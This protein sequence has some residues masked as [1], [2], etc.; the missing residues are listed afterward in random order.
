MDLLRRAL[1]K[2][3]N[4]TASRQDGQVLTLFAAGLVGLCGFVG[5]SIDV[6]QLVY[7]ASDVQKIADAAALAG[8]Q[9]LPNTSN[10]TSAAT[11]YAAENGTA[12]LDITFTNS[13]HTIEV[14][15][16][17]YVE[18]TFLK[19]IGLG[20]RTISRS[21]TVVAQNQVI[22]GYTL[23]NTAPFIIW[24]GSRQTE[25]NPGDQH[26]ALHTCVG[27][28]YTFLDSNW[29]NA[30]GKPKMP[31]WNSSDSNNFKGDINHGDGAEVNH[32]GETM[33]VGG[34]GSVDVP[35]VG[36]IL[37]I[38]VVDKA[39]GNSNMRT[40]HIAAWVQVQVQPG[41]TK[42][43]CKGKVLDPNTTSPSPGWVGGGS[44]ASPPSLTYT[45]MTTHLTK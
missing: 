32:V 30:S 7:T 24:G 9:D 43:G 8:A 42:N 37:V 31:D 20:G 11:T 27:K 4:G 33:S 39:G 26:C 36:T 19:V 23:A 6:G 29:M 15:A 14:E 28:S 1:R 18:Y 41:C 10:A 13:H 5:L 12:A 21:A 35:A 17:R 25:V 2:L 3:G 40:F 22:T 45:G 44:V 38:P 16:S 34:L